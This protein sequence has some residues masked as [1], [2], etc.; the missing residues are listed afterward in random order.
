MEVRGRMVA[1]GEGG[2]GCFIG[3]EQS[4]EVR[5]CAGRGCV[6][7]KLGGKKNLSY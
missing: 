5:V 4:G 7:V 3:A 1:G 2:E 6:P